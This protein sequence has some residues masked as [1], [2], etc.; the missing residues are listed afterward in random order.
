MHFEYLLLIE[1]L[2]AT[3]RDSIRGENPSQAALRRAVSTAYYALLHFLLGISAD[4]LITMTAS[5]R[6]A[7][8]WHQVYRSPDHRQM[9]KAC[10]KILT[11]QFP[12]Q[13]E[14]LA[15]LFIEMQRER[16]RADYDLSAHFTKSD[17]L[18]HI[19]SVERVMRAFE[20]TTPEDRQAFA[21]FILFKTRT[22]P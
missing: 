14:E 2:I 20:T 13:I 18:S 17:V 22:T 6:G 19:D 5:P 16:Q 3:A 4:A 11:Q 1:G 10:E 9:R 8:T 21:A 12:P 15:E 7:Y